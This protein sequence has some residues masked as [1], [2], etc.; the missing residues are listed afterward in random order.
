M[1][2]SSSASRYSFHKRVIDSFLNTLAQSL[3]G[4]TR[5]LREF[6]RL[7]RSLWPVYIEP[8][9]PSRIEITMG[10]VKKNLVQKS[11]SPLSEDCSSIESELQALLDRT[12]F[13]HISAALS[14]GLFSLSLDSPFIIC[15]VAKVSN[16]QSVKN[17]PY[18]LNCLLLAAFVCQNNRPDKDKRVFSIHGNGKRRARNQVHDA[19]E[20]VAYGSTVG[21]QQQLKMLRPR[22]F[23]LERMLSIFVTIVGLN[24]AN[25]RFVVGMEDREE[26][27]QTLGSS[28]LYE[29]LA[30][31]RDLGYLHEAKYNGSIKA[32]QMNLNGSKY[33]CSLTREEADILA[34]SMGIPLDN[35]LL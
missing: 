15:P 29:N 8:L 31:L 28:H 10:L 19:E 7:G 18:L 22:P 9:Q 33:W 5:D 21:E 34:K 32:E 25:A 35:Y 24:P 1:E 6:V 20:D 23:P 2:L 26:I 17:Q 4:S 14:E 27:L 30:Q 11:A 13:P 12:F 3:S 16:G